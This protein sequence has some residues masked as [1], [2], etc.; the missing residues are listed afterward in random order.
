MYLNYR[1]YLPK[2]RKTI[3]EL[4]GTSKRR[5]NVKISLTSTQ[6]AFKL[7][8]FLCLDIPEDVSN[9]PCPPPFGCPW[10]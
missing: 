10:R 5:E 4:L 9:P 7:T 3:S 1:N 6:K 2:K 8:N